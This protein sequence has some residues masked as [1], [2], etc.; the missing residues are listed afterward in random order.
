M[1]EH[2]A[3]RATRAAQ[4]RAVVRGTRKACWNRRYARP[5]RFHTPPAYGALSWAICVQAPPNGAQP[6]TAWQS[7]SASLHQIQPGSP[8]AASSMSG[9]PEVESE[10]RVRVFD[11]EC[12]TFV[13]PE[14]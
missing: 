7:N 13:E 10:Y 1:I 5:T 12:P 9:F 11:A 2:R 6:T 3:L 14:L 4:S 8:P